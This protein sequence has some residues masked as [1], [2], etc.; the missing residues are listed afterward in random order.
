LS[1]WFL[2]PGVL[3]TVITLTSTLVSSTTLV[4]EKDSGTLEQLLMTPADAWEILLAKIAPLFVLLM[5]DILLALSVARIVFRVPL[6]GSLLLFLALGGLYL[7]V[8][9]GVGLMLAT[10]AKNQQQVVLTSFFINLPLIQLSGAIAPIESMPVFF[11]YLSLLNPL[12]HFVAISR[13]ILLKGVGIDILFPHVIALFTFVV[14]LLTVS[15]NR[16]RSQLS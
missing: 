1:S 5:G 13:G 2:V 16:F 12:R 6:Q 15:V 3:G 8:G 14:V 9:I 7:F 4:R 10:L 11:Q